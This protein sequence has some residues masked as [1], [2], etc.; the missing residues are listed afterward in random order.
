MFRKKKNSLFLKILLSL[1]VLAAVL[2][3]CVFWGS[4]QKPALNKDSDVLDR[5]ERATKTGSPIKLSSDDLNYLIDIA[6]VNGMQRKGVTIN[7]VSTRLKND[8]L[9]AFVRVKY[10][11]IPLRLEAKGSIQYNGGNQL[12][13][14]ASSIHVG[15]IPIP[16]G[17]VMHQ[18]ARFAEGHFTADEANRTIVVEKS[19]LPMDI[20]S[21]AV[22]DSQ[23]VV[24]MPHIDLVKKVDD[25]IERETKKLGIIPQEA[26]SGKTG[27]KTDKA[28]KSSKGSVTSSAGKELVGLA[29]STANKL[30][31]NPNY[32][33]QRA[34]VQG[35]ALYSKLSSEE[36]EAVKA[37]VLSRVNTKRLM[38]VYRSRKKQ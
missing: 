36:K 15:L 17:L 8:E 4:S 34:L 7:C 27:K 24:G 16:T 22:K 32:S 20:K 30:M 18:L 21:V 12:I 33:Y 23:L 13:L 3:V 14:K 1:A 31:S 26:G 35:R 37:A 25:A 19:K 28:P 9:T 38:E 5:I 6:G 10:K 11:G 29:I 2:L